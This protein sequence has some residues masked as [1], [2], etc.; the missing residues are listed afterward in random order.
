MPNCKK[1]M[2][3]IYSSDALNVCISVTIIE[4]IQHFKLWF[5]ATM[6]LGDKAS[7]IV[8]SLP[9]IEIQEDLYKIDYIISKS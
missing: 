3:W 8:C 4:F 5:N 7:M 6:N 9:K 2:Q 1:Q